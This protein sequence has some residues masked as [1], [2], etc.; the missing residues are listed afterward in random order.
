MIVQYVYFEKSYD[1][2]HHNGT[3]IYRV[4]LERI[5]ESSRTLIAAN[6]PA[7]GPA[8]SSRIAARA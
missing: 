1:Q 8:P 4:T 7:T 2:F 6:H 5:Q 3:N